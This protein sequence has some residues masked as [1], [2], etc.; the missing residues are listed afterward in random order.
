MVYPKAIGLDSARG[1]AIV[2][3]TQLGAVLDVNLTTGTRSLISD[4]S[5]P[6]DNNTYNR[7]D[8]V[9]S[10]SANDRMLILDSGRLA[11]ISESLSTNKRMII[12]DKRTPN[13]L[14]LFLSP[15]DF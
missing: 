15:V 12:S 11:L 9:V 5:L 6:D 3:D 2:L 1:R 7:I 14:N 4:N 13:D 10:D 8:A